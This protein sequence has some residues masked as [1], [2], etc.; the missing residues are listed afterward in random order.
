MW[1]FNS[2]DNA[3]APLLTVLLLES[4]GS[5]YEHLARAYWGDEEGRAHL[6]SV[7]A[8]LVFLG[9]SGLPGTAL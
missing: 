2:F 4:H 7:S 8:N 3:L 5:I 1:L 6:P 9:G